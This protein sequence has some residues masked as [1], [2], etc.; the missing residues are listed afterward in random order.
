ML[1]RSIFTLVTVLFFCSAQASYAASISTSVDR[2]RISMDETVVLSIRVSPQANTTPNFSELETQ[3]DILNRSQ[4]SQYRNIN[5]Q[6]TAFTEWQLTLAPKSTGKLV[7]PSIQYEQE[8]SDAIILEVAETDDTQSGLTPDIFLDIQAEKSE[9]YVQEQVIITV[10]LHTAIP[11]RVDDAPALNIP[12]ALLLPLKDSQYQKRIGDKVYSV[13]ELR[14]AL[15]PQMSGELEIPIQTFTV[16]MRAN[17]NFSNP[18][19]YGQT[20]TKRIRS[21]PVMLSVK[22]QAKGYQGEQ[23]LPASKLEI[24]EQWSSDT[25]D[26]T[27]GEPITRKITL[28]ATGLS[29]NQIPSLSLAESQSFKQYREK[30]ESSDT[31]D[32]RGLSTTITESIAIVPTQEGATQ[33]P[34]V[35]LY[36]WD[37][38]SN[39]QKIALLPA[40]NINIKANPQLPAPKTP[41]LA[42]QPSSDAT[43]QTIPDTTPATLEGV[44]ATVIWQILTA[45][46]VAT[47]LSLAALVWHLWRRSRPKLHLP[48]PDASAPQSR[49]QELDK[50]FSQPLNRASAAYFLRAFNRHFPKQAIDAMA[51]QSL[52]TELKHAIQQLNAYTYGDKPHYEGDLP[53]LQSL[54]RQA[55]QQPNKS[56]A[57]PTPLLTGLYPD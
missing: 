17:S 13:S 54:V 50:F 39:T 24:S 10:K 48:A 5:G 19:N 4:N 44:H 42:T 23:W 7:I 41:I 37:T 49:L 21:R 45:L 51:D 40:R 28:K 18:L 9:P 29:A 12:N 11:L 8:F 3:F 53:T 20:E 34:E 36:W 56:S 52:A 6:V 32:A 25:Q 1:I 30:P 15:F 38:Q 46:L 57:L 26:W 22:P 47:N 2:A 35:K 31:Q 16:T 55:T 33:L 27:L 43:E 14:Y